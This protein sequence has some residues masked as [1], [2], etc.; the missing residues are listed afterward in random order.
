MERIILFVAGALAILLAFPKFR[1]PIMARLFN[2]GII[3]PHAVKA[4]DAELIRYTG[5]RFTLLVIGVV[6]IFLGLWI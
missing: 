6:L 5:P 3:M 1:V 2:E 4:K